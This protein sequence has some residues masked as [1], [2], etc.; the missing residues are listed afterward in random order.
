VGEKNLKGLPETN[1][2]IPP[3][4]YPYPP[5]PQVEDDEIDLFEIFLI[6]KKRFKWILGSLFIF[7]VGA[8]LYIFLATPIYRTE[9]SLLPIVIKSS[10]KFIQINLTPP[11]PV[12][13][14]SRS[15]E[16][17]VI[18]K[19]N[20]IPLLVNEDEIRTN[21]EKKILAI[22]I[23]RFNKFITV[24]KD[25][26]SNVVHLYVEA[27]KNPELSYQVTKTL[28][29]EAAK[30]IDKLKNTTIQPLLNSIKR[31]IERIQ[32]VLEKNKNTSNVNFLT[33]LLD[34]YTSQ[35]NYLLSLKKTPPFQIISPPY[36]PIKA[37][38][39]KKLLIL[40][41]AILAGFFFGIFLAFFV[42][43]LENAKNRF[44]DFQG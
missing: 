27:P 17:K 1:Q 31:E 7:V 24:T 33:A 16:L 22:A 34:E 21:G 42:E 4:P 10:G 38:K 26:N 13:L 20:L 35:Y 15:V 12:I 37:Y 5:Y 29:S 3:Y 25:R 40:T 6:L 28:L 19:L 8:I 9:T 43:W 32:A 23:D 14:K 11:L 2:N 30:E 36:V 41:I 44:K 18:R 39:P